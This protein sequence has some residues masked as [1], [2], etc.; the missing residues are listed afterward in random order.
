MNIAMAV[1]LEAHRN[2]SGTALGLDSKAWPGTTVGAKTLIVAGGGFKSCP[3]RYH[4][5][6][7]SPWNYSN[8]KKRIIKLII[9]EVIIIDLKVIKK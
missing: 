7:F 3:G 9:I 8:I 4:L 2:I 6:T 1:P 5:L